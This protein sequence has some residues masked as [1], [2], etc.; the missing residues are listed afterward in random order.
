M[1]NSPYVI[2]VAFAFAWVVVTW[3]RARYGIEHHGPGWEHKPRNMKVPPMFDKMVSKAMEERD[4]EISALKE[5]V[6]VL[7][8]I[9]TDNHSSNRLSDEIE[10]LRERR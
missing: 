10:K 7:E 6:E 1:F 3:I 5:R 4:A 2:P 8:K 9:V